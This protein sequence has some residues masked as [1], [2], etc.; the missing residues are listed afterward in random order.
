MNINQEPQPDLIQFLSTCPLFTNLQANHLNEVAPLLEPLSYITGDTVINQGEAGDCLYIVQ[1]GRLNIVSQNAAGEEVILSNTTVGG[2]VGEIALLTGARRTASVYATEAIQLLRLSK[3]RFDELNQQHAEIAAQI[4]QNII[5]KQYRVLLDMTLRVSNLLKDIDKAVLQDLLEL[6]EINLLRST[7]TLVREGEES[8]A[9]YIVINGRLRVTVTTEDGSQS[10]LLELGRG[11]TVGEAGLITGEKRSAT[12]YA[13]RDTVLARLSQTAFNQL[14]AKHPQAMM[15][16]FAA[17]VI[18]RLQGQIKGRVRSSKLVANLAFVPLSP[19]IPLKTLV[20][21]LTKQLRHRDTALHLN[22]VT[23]EKALNQEGIAQI[24]TDDPANINIVSWLAEQETQYRYIIYEADATLSPW[25]RRCLRQADHIVLVANANNPPTLT[26]IEKEITTFRTNQNPE[27]LSLVLLHPPS[28]VQPIG[29]SQWLTARQVGHH[30][31]VKQDNTADIARLARLLTG[32]GI[33]LVLS[34]GGARG[35]AHIGAFRALRE[36]DIPIDLVGGSSAGGLIACQFAMG[37]SFD[38]IMALTAASLKHKFDYTFPMTALMAGGS[39]VKVV[40]E[41]FG[42]T[43]IEDMWLPCF[44]T[45]TN[46]STAKLMIHTQGPAWKYI[47]ATSSIPGVLPPVMDNGHMLIDGGV[48]N[49][50]PVDIMRQRSDVGV[51]FASDVGASE[52]TSRSSEPSYETHLSGW[53]VLWRRINPLTKPMQVPSIGEIMMQI[54][55]LSNRQTSG[56]TRDLADFYM[57][58]S[59]RGHGMLEFDALEAIVAKGYKAAQEQIALWETA[60][61][62]Q[63]FR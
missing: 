20:N 59:V 58:L 33:S 50:L 31:H 39:M 35:F 4:S 27:T 34:G 29:T 62:F 22:R 36:A 32:Q 40:Q 19:D 54:A 42:T 10:A 23:L 44:C 3:G 46:L 41:M 8:D 11:E 57:G 16:Q 60:E 37:W 13:L 55:V 21:Q 25:T 48:L 9:L 5:Q 38:K 63:A 24:R 1:R 14:L 17:T 45:S 52:H 26:T 15:Q 30:Y 49:N 61:L 18:S 53:Q 28:T 6:L 47:R 51:V 12:V 2:T 43:A 56:A 7:E